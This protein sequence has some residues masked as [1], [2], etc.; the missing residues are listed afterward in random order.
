M[1]RFLTKTALVLVSAV[2]LVL[3]F[4]FGALWL[5]AYFAFIPYFFAL[6]ATSAGE[7]FKL[8]TIFGVVFFGLLGYW[9]TFVSVLG[10]VLLSL[11]LALYFSMFGILIHRFLNPANKASADF[12]PVN[13]FDRLDVKKNVQA[14]LF[15]P[16][17]WVALEYL[18]GWIISGLPWALLAHSQ[19]TNLPVIQI[20]DLTGV[21]G[22]SY[23]VMAVNWLF[24]RLL[25]IFFSWKKSQKESPEFVAHQKRLL[26]GLSVLLTTICLGVVGYGL[27]SLRAWDRFYRNDFP[28]AG[29]RVSVIQGNIPQ[30]QKWNTKIK[31]II[32]EKYRRL[33][34]MSGIERSD[35]IIWPETSFP[36]FLEDEPVLSAELRRVVRQARTEVLVGAPTLGNL[37]EGLRFYNSA[38]HYGPDGE[39]KKR[40]DKIH[41]VPFG[42]FVPFEGLFGIIRNFVS[43]GHFSPGKTFTLF[44]TQ[45][46]Y[47][48]NNIQARFAVLICYEDIFPGL[49]RRFCS[50]GAD[51]LVNM[52]NDA[53][54]GDTT[55]PY[56]HAQASV[57]RA[58]ENRVPVVRATNTGFSCFVSPE[59]RIL[60]RVEDNG[61][62]IFVT[63]HK[64]CD[65][66]LRKTKTF[67]TR[68]GDVFVLA[69][70]FLCFLAFREKSRHDAYVRL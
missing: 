23:F 39:E 64:G 10:F 41:L 1:P 38:V 51:F 20:A 68:F 61:K 44:T 22:V 65:L 24:F 19:W 35:L 52:T 21:Y 5:L 26:M 27:F 7:S 56:Q 33:T 57:F 47:Q 6:N 3:P 2:L 67:Y 34:F 8:S 55:A 15:V 45:T 50:D 30:D 70:F 18:R 42:E 16:A 28:K 66:I 49:V 59:G 29:L 11:Y 37:E 48:K 43:I 4:H 31:N 32:F 69:T 12:Q 54:F 17:F 46:R 53:W 63:G 14:A 62:E 25:Q 40:Y 58:V 60:A 13:S 36:G 9:L